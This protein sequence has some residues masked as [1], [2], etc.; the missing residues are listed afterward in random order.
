MLSE[1]YPTDLKEL[2]ALARHSGYLTRLLDWTFDLRVALYFALQGVIEA[3]W[4]KKNQTTEKNE[5]EVEPYYAVWCINPGAIKQME[6]DSYNQNNPPPCPIDFFVPSYNRNINLK[7]QS[8]LL[9]YQKALYSQHSKNDRVFTEETHDQ[10]MLD[11]IEVINNKYRNHLSDGVM[12]C[13]I[14][15]PT[16]NALEEFRW[17]IDQGYHAAKLFPGYNGVVQKIEE[18]RWVNDLFFNK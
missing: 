12:I 2:A 15:L 17:L 7:A 11:Y 1:W 4:K 16:I 3:Q 18:D 8:G 13:K 9:S 14:N 6:G 10:I 5:I